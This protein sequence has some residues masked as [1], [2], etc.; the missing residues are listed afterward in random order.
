MQLG[1][2]GDFSYDSFLK[3]YTIHKKAKNEWSKHDRII[4]KN[5]K[6]SLYFSFFLLCCFKEKLFP[7][8]FD[9][10]FFLLLLCFSSI[11][12]I[13]QSKKI[14]FIQSLESCI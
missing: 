14:C 6:S 8:T 1:I 4:I 12:T 11:A 10:K 2:S 5:N 9:I 13:F 7:G 3:L